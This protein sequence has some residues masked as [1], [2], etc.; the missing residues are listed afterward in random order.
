VAAENKSL[1]DI[2]TPLSVVRAT[3]VGG[4]GT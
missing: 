1:E 3:G 2:A 4:V